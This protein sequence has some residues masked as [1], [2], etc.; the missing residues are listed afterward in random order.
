MQL[1]PTL[2]EP[3]RPTCPQSIVSDP[4]CEAWPIKTRSSSL[5]P[6]PIRVS[7]T[8]A[9]S[10][11]AFACTSTSSSSTAG[12][13]C[14]ILYQVPSFCFAKPSPSPPIT[15]PFCRITRSPMRQNSRTL[16]DNGCRMDPRRITWL[17]IKKLE[18]V[19]KREIRIR[20]AQ[21]GKRREIGMTRHLDAFLDQNRG[22]KRGME[23]RKVP[24]IR[25]E[26]YL[27]RFGVL[28]SSH[29]ANLEFRRA[30]QAAS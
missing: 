20:R 13:D 19:G 14:V 29:P 23:Q 5:V 25:E 27:P 17:L 3:A 7:P 24:P 26:C 11:H 4:T 6:R 8:V 21:R 2:V 9:R 15:T 22:G 30:F 12:P 10:T 18:R 16:R 1:R 28:H